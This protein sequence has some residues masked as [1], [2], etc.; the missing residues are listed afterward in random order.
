MQGE[1]PFFVCKNGTTLQEPFQAVINP[2]T[3][4]HE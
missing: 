2:L 1:A 4:S 3:S